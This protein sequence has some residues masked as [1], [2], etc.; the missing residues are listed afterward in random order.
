MNVFSSTCPFPLSSS[1]TLLIASISF[2][3]LSNTFRSFSF[4]SNRYFN[5]RIFYKGIDRQLEGLMAAAEYACTAEE[6]D[7]LHSERQALALFQHHDGITGTAKSFVVQDYFQT[8]E[9][10][11][12]SLRH[13]IAACLGVVSHNGGLVLF[14][15][16]GLQ[17]DGLQSWEVKA[18]TGTWRRIEN[19]IYLSVGKFV[20]E[21]KVL[22]LRWVHGGPVLLVLVAFFLFGLRRCHVCM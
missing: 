2:V 3:S 11:M 20:E 18:Q 21:V 17:R 5:S 13:K 8:M 7:A 9:R 22:L 14:N 6:A 19:Y 4:F 12:D 16:T 15:P 1:P 10:A